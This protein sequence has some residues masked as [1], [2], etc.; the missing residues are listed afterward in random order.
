MKP[1]IDEINNLVYLP[2]THVV[3]RQYIVSEDLVLAPFNGD[4]QLFKPSDFM[5]RTVEQLLIPQPLRVE[6]YRCSDVLQNFSLIEDRQERHVY[7]AKILANNPTLKG[8]L[9]L[10][11][12]FPPNEESK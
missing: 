7:V 10:D 8:K 3:L 9:N 12:P 2:H 4:K 5:I 6:V 11:K 1:P